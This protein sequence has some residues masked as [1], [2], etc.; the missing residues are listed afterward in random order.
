MAERD[1]TLVGDNN[2]FAARMIEAGDRLLDA[3][4]QVELLPAGNVGAFPRLAVQYAV[5]IQE[6]VGDISE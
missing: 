2:Y 1:A 5:P 6:D 4:K 3:G